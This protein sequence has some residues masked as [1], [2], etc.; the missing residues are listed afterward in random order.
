MLAVLPVK[1]FAAAKSRLDGVLEPS[2]RAAL[3]RAVARRVA[4]ACAAAGAEVVVVTPD[5]EVACWAVEAGLEVLAEP[6]GGGLDGAATA[7]AALA[8]GR[9]SAWCIVHA[10]LPLLTPAHLQEIAAGARPGTAVLAPSRHG[11]TNLLAGTQPMPF[12]YGPGSFHRHLAAARH[13]E[14]RVLVTVGTALD[15]D[16]PE[17]LRAAASLPGGAWLRDYLT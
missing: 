9:G 15:L 11:G 14:R 10:D 2:R 1:G 13:L 16:T 12:A 5:E 17:D 8:R 6:P 4:A 7:G 3:S